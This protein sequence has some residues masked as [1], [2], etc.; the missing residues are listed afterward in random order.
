MIRCAMR[1]S[2]HGLLR[3]WRFLIIENDARAR[4]GDLFVRAHL[5][6][7]TNTPEEY[8]DKLRM[9]P[10]RAPTMVAVIAKLVNHPKVPELEQLLS[11][12]GAAQILLLAAQAKGYGGIWRTGAPAYDHT[13]T[14]GLGLSEH[15]RLVAFLY[16]GTPGKRPEIPEPQADEHILH[17]IDVHQTSPVSAEVFR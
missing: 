12:G 14:E 13:V 17:W 9:A 2:D 6:G 4:L 15:E 10:L 3:P 5:A 11:A 16:L 1:A 8:L 7:S